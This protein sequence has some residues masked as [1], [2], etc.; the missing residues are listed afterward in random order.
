MIAEHEQKKVAGKVEYDRGDHPEPRRR[1]NIE[2]SCILHQ[3]EKSNDGIQ[4]KNDRLHSNGNTVH[5]HDSLEERIEYGYRCKE[6]DHHLHA[7][8][9]AFEIDDINEKETQEYK[10]QDRVDAQ[11][12]GGIEMLIP[13]KVR[14][15]VCD[16]RHDHQRENTPGR[17][18]KMA[19]AYNPDQYGN[20]HVTGRNLR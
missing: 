1:K 16:H 15:I 18:G 11:K 9:Q 10:F 17:N 6:H 3:Q 7:H 4:D 12:I 19:E 20:N 8:F 14:D 5:R 13:E 2:I